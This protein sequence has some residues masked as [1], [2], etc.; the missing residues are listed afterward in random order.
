M[1]NCRFGVQVPEL[2]LSRGVPSRNIV[3]NDGVGYI[4][5]IN[6]PSSLLLGADVTGCKILQSIAHPH[7]ATIMPK[8]V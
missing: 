7:L 6:R 5:K 2:A 1:L 8:D 4:K 3:V